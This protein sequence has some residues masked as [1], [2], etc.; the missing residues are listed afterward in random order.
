MRYCPRN[1]SAL[2]IQ[3]VS[4]AVGTYDSGN[5]VKL[6]GPPLVVLITI[7]HRRILLFV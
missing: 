3:Y 1:N 4:K 2:Y 5:S 7:N 6:S